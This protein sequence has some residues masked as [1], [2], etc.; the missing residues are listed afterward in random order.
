MRPASFVARSREACSR[1]T[2]Y[3]GGPYLNE[4]VYEDAHDNPH[5]SGDTMEGPHLCH[6][7]TPDSDTPPPLPSRT[8][9]TGDLPLAAVHIVSSEAPPTSTT[10]NSAGNEAEHAYL[11]LIS[12]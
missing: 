5:P 4:N 10:S 2:D 8:P 1:E 11:K 9:S 7:L 6:H 3:E 12:G